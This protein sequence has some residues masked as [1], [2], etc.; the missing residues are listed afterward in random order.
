MNHFAV[1]LKHCISTVLQLK[2]KCFLI[3]DLR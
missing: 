2:T 3:N 1:H